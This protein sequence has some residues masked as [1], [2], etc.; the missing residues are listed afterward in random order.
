MPKPTKKAEKQ[1]EI[2]ADLELHPDAWERF[3]AII[4][5]VGK[6]PEN[7]KK[8]NSKISSKP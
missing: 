2:P 5:S 7:E 6:A 1:I 3:E 4:K 8:G